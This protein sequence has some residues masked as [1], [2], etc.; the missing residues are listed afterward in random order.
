MALDTGS[1]DLWLVSSACSSKQF[2]D[3]VPSYPL[4]FHSP[5]FEVVNNNLTGFNVSFA[6]GTGEHICLLTHHPTTYQDAPSVASGFLAK[7]TVQLSNLSLGNQVFGRPPLF[8]MNN[9]LLNQRMSGLVNAS[10]VSLTNDI[11]GV[12]GM[13]FPRLSVFSSL[14]NNS[15]SLSHLQ[16]MLKLTSRQ[17]HHS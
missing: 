8:L 14:V 1:S 4:S 3:S 5:S 7:E 15:T 11:S 10:N 13:G 12:L 9:R 2:C 17:Q 6:D 16:Y